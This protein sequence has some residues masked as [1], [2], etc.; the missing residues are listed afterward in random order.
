MQT[1]CRKYQ[2]YRLFAFL[3]STFTDFTCSL[4]TCRVVS[5]SKSTKIKIGLPGVGKLHPCLLYL[6]H[7]TFVL[8][9]GTKLAVNEITNELKSMKVNELH[10]ETAKDLIERRDLEDI[11]FSG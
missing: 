7:L 5:P 6:D 8:S 11:L 4:V 10:S 3:F 9:T 2:V 1:L